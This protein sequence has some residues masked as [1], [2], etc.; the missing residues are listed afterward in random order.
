[1]RSNRLFYAFAFQKADGTEHILS[2]GE[3]RYLSSEVAGGFTGV[4]IALYAS[5]NGRNSLSPA[6]FDWF[7]YSDADQ[8]GFLSIDS[9][10]AELFQREEAREVIGKYFPNLVAHPPAEWGAALSLLALSA[11]S[12]DEFPPE[13]LLLLD[14]ELRRTHIPSH[15]L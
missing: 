12:P 3:T 6:Y 2:T 4:Y 1:M 10:V 7:D 11:M 5:G 14:A 13:T 8:P 15:S 9:T